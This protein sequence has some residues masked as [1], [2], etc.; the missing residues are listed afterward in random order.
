[1]TTDELL[2]KLAQRGVQVVLGKDGVPKLCGDK[3]I[4]TPKLRRVLRWHRDAIIERLRPKP[5]RE[6]LW[7]LGHRYTDHPED[8]MPGTWLPVGAWWYRYE[9]EQTWQAIPG[10]AG[11]TTAPP[12]E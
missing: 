5:R 8:N 10:R 2:A 9:G 12:A 3:T 4:V 7:R 1:M 11:E 6:F